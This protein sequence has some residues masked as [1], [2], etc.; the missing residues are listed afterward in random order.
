MKHGRNTHEDAHRI[1]DAAG[2]DRETEDFGWASR[3][4]A[5]FSEIGLSD[6]EATALEL[7]ETCFARPA[8]LE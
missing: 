1:I 8:E 6:E 5:Q 4:S 2:G 7:R 3:V